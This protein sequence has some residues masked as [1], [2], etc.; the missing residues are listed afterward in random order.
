M[1]RQA[2][3]QIDK[4]VP[5]ALSVA[6]SPSM[7]YQPLAHSSDHLN[8]TGQYFEYDSPVVIA[9]SDLHRP[10]PPIPNAHRYFESVSS[11]QTVESDFSLQTVDS[12]S[13]DIDS[14]A[15]RQSLPQCPGTP[16]SQFFDSDVADID[17]TASPQSLPQS[18]S[19]P[20][21]QHFGSD[22]GDVAPSA[23][24]Q[25]LPHC[26]DPPT[27]QHVDFN[28]PSDLQH[29]WTYDQCLNYLTR[30][31]VLFMTSSDPEPFYFSLPSGNKLQGMT[32]DQRAECVRK[33]LIEQYV[34]P[35]PKS[36]NYLKFARM[37]RH[38]RI[39]KDTKH[40]LLSTATANSR[41]NRY[42]TGIIHDHHD[43]HE[44]TSRSI[45]INGSR[46]GY[47]SPWST[48]ADDGKGDSDWGDVSDS[49]WLP[50]QSDDWSPQKQ[51]T[52]HASSARSAKYGSK[53]T[54]RQKEL[55]VR[56]D[57]AV[58]SDSDNDLSPIEGHRSDRMY[59][60][61]SY[62]A[63]FRLAIAQE[64]DVKEPETRTTSGIKPPP[65]SDQDDDIIG[66]DTVT[67]SSAHALLSNEA[68]QNG[69]GRGV[70][71]DDPLVGL[72]ERLNL[73]K[74]D[75]G[76]DARFEHLLEQITLAIEELEE[77]EHLKIPFPSWMGL[78][79][80]E[81]T[82]N[83]GHPSQEYQMLL[84]HS[85]NERLRQMALQEEQ[86]FIQLRAAG[87]TT[88]DGSRDSLGSLG[89]VRINAKEMSSP[90][91]L[92]ETKQLKV[93]EVRKVTSSF[94][95]LGM[96]PSERA[97]AEAKN[98]NINALKK[99]SQDFKLTTPVPDDIAFINDGEV[100]VTVWQDHSAHP[101]NTQPT[102]PLQIA[103][104]EANARRAEG[105]KLMPHGSSM[106]TVVV[107]K[108]LPLGTPSPSPANCR[109]Y[110]PRAAKYQQHDV[111]PPVD[112]CTT[113]QNAIANLD[114]HS[115]KKEEEFLM[116]AP[117]ASGTLMNTNNWRSWIMDGGL[118]NRGLEQEGI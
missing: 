74:R 57:I 34:R 63:D 80:Q 12:R 15:S 50:T 47:Q 61:D 89:F 70:R 56:S 19:T 55:D 95:V 101:A 11:I 103:L 29:P 7:P 113:Q 91:V 72:F 31:M 82:Q 112:H 46:D 4:G 23:S 108:V 117:L 115:P 97:V 30:R 9:T 41:V 104:K 49:G 43:Y 76:R 78:P 68:S 94:P 111:T 10:L 53:S 107:T 84:D 33:H 44:H 77:L 8:P 65:T 24:R 22:W 75:V 102:A 99:F 21:S 60:R 118:R 96:T 69:G 67:E 27:S 93:N 5:E 114:I 1:T 39:V 13:A 45:N 18:P 109:F 71:Q 54:Y 6:D 86:G 42:R 17:S 25:P 66:I 90:A 52:K 59:L 3:E 110:I 26:P 73:V 32:P 81:S 85:N 87:Q 35:V 36:D 51:Q 14:Y 98:I 58:Y 40:N 28:L 79:G 38:E 62:T 48:D 2:P 64:S 16:S 106:K 37:E 83:D 92:K 100:P 105:R 20:T 116:T 88:S